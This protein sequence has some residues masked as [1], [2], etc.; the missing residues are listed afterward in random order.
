MTKTTTKRIWTAPTVRRI[1]AQSAEGA[2]LTVRQDG[3][4]AQGS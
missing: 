4:F 1:D 2:G 3:Q